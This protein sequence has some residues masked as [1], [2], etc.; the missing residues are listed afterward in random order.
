MT[1][2]W[3]LQ[4]GA[5]IRIVKTFRDGAGN[6]FA[7]GTILHFTHR[8]YLPYHSGHTVFFREA[9]M[10]LSDDDETRAIVENERDEY[11]TVIGQLEDRTA[12][13]MGIVTQT[14]RRQQ[15]KTVLAGL[16]SVGLA[17]GIAIP[18]GFWLRP[19]YP[20]MSDNA[21][22]AIIVSILLGISAVSMWLLAGPLR[23][24]KRRPGAPSE[25]SS[26]TGY[27]MSLDDFQRLVSEPSSQVVVA[28]LLSDWYRYQIFGQGPET[29]VR[30]A[31]GQV[32]DLRVLHR[33]IQ[34]DSSKQ[35]TIYQRAMDL[36]R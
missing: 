22:A 2:V 36:W 31:N 34:V 32:I 7:E 5:V 1:N 33:Q 16:F 15:Q 10:Y 23:R 30:S 13:S 20:S 35:Y 17:F 6:E 21:F 28:P 29:V 12:L 27:E 25:T 14:A 24:V 18:L 8:N 26:R 3:N 9:T 4:P 19:L 11:F